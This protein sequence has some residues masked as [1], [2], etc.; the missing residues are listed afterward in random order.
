[1]RL[2]GWAVAAVIGCMASGGFCT[3]GECAKQAASS[4]QDCSPNGG[5]GGFYCC[6]EGEDA[7]VDAPV[8]H[9]AG[10]TCVTPPVECATPAGG[11]C[12]AGPDIEYE[13][14]ILAPTS[15]Q[16]CGSHACCLDLVGTEC[17]AAGGT[18]TS[19]PC[20]VGAPIS[21]QDCET[22]PP[23]PA[24]FSCCLAADASD[25]SVDGGSDASDAAGE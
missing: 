5:F 12:D 6:L 13:C 10:G 17:H 15:A 20:A 2:L 25:A 11:A 3:V 14:A 18:C 4:A 8:C 24:G 9:A 7:S 23:N 19:S 16:D 21:A 22:N 1:M